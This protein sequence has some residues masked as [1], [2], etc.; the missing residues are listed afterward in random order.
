MNTRTL[1]PVRALTRA[2][3]DGWACC[4][5]GR[6]LFRCG[7]ISAGIARGHMG[8]HVLDIEVYACHECGSPTRESNDQIHKSVHQQGS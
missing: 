6:S 5:C 7:G 1:P 3:H 4:W 2:Q 8:A